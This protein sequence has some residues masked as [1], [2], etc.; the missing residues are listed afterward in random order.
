M[1]DI[2][3]RTIIS[4]LTC[5]FVFATLQA[6]PQRQGRNN[7]PL[8]ASA[9]FSKQNFRP[10]TSNRVQVQRQRQNYSQ[11]KQISQRFYKNNT[12]KK[13]IQSVSQRP[14]SNRPSLGN[15]PNKP[16]IRPPAQRPNNRPNIGERPPKPNVVIHRPPPPRPALLP[17][18]RRH[19]YRGSTVV[20]L[21]TN[22]DTFSYSTS[23]DIDL[24]NRQLRTKIINK[25]NKLNIPDS[26]LLSISVLELQ[27]DVGKYYA[28]IEVTATRERDKKTFTI[29]SE[30]E[31]YLLSVLENNLAENVADAIYSAISQEK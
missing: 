1:E 6:S 20:Y 22:I 10:Q 13:N 24:F 14:P 12:I 8:R 21:P 5:V 16:N 11:P 4:I 15:R 28:E 26:Y 9:N 19:F 2:M 31:A 25:L 27:K 3:K 18:P 30:N 29:F 17:P 7:Q 23:L